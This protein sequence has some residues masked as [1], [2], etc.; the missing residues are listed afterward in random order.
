[1]STTIARV[2]VNSSSLASVG[3]APDDGVLEAEFRSG[4]IYRFFLVP[5]AVWNQLLAAPSKGAFFNERI[6][7]QFPVANVSRNEPIDLTVA[8]AKSIEALRNRDD[9]EEPNPI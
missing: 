6:K 4:D 1:M 7:D 2:P 8:L 3:Y 9:A 5:A